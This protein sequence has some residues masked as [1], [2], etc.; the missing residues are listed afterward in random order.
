MNNDLETIIESAQ[1]ITL[2]QVD[3]GTLATAVTCAD[4]LAIARHGR[5]E[6]YVVPKHLIDDL[7]MKVSVLESDNKRLLG[8]HV[9]GSLTIPPY[10]GDAFRGLDNFLRSNALKEVFKLPAPEIHKHMFKSEI[11]LLVKKY[12]L[13]TVKDA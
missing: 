1:K 6:S 13:T 3:N 12:P 5:V 10:G 8:E 7:L 2:G 4:T 9:E 11:A